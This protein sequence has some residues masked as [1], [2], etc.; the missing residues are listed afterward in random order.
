LSVTGQAL[1]R[2]THILVHQIANQVSGP[3]TENLLYEIAA[4][5]GTIASSGSSL[6]TGPRTAGGKLNDFMTPLECRFTGEISHKAAGIEP[7]KMNEIVK[8]LLPKYE[9]TI[10]DPD[11]GRSFQEAYDVEA[12]K[13]VPE[14]EEIYRR[15]KAEMIELGIPL[16]PY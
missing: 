9:D 3:V 13:P 16:D 12:L 14:W 1:S 15:V 7:Q 5:V 2:N 10:K 4:G 6:T 11:V 8:E